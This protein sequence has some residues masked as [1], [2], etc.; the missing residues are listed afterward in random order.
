[1]QKTAIANLRHQSA[2]VFRDQVTYEPWHDVQCMYFFCDEDRALL[3]PVQTQLAAALGERAI[4]FT[5][6]GRSHSPFLSAPD[7][8]V[9][10]LLYGVAEA[11]KRASSS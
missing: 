6:K 7:E 2:Q 9:E 4:T 10:G 5:A 11:E 8:V 3:P 1:M